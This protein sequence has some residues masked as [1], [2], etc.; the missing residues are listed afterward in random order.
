MGH[1][2]QRSDQECCSNKPI[3]LAIAILV[4]TLTLGAL[5]VMVLRGYSIRAWSDPVNWLE[6]A[7]NFWTEF[8]TSRLACGYPLFLRA[9]LLF[10]GPYLVF[11][12]NL[13]LLLIL[14]GAAGAMA[15]ALTPGAAERKVAAALFTIAIGVMFDPWL[16]QVM[17]NPYRDP[18]SHVLLFG[19]LGVALNELPRAQWRASR[20]FTAGLLL[21]L[22][23]SVREPALLA[24][25]PMAGLMIARGWRQGPRAVVRAAGWA[26]AGT[27]AGAAPLLAQGLLRA[28]D[29]GLLPPQT[30]AE[31]RWLPGMHWVAFSEVAPQVAKYLLHWPR[32]TLLWALPFALGVGAAARDR[33]GPVIAL[34]VI[35]TVIYA[36]FYCF[37]WTFVP[38]Y[39]W[40]AVI[41]GAAVGGWGLA[42]LLAPLSRRLARGEWFSMGAAILACVAAATWILG[43]RPPVRRFRIV[44]AR[45]LTQE[46]ATRV[47]SGTK[48]LARRHFCEIIRWFNQLDAYPASWHWAADAVDPTESLRE[49]ISRE[50]AADRPVWCAEVRYG[51][52]RDIE[53]AAVRR[54]FDFEPTGVEPLELAPFGLSSAQVEFW[55]IRPWSTTTSVV[56]VYV[57]EPGMR[58]EVDARGISDGA[59][60]ILRDQNSQWQ[61]DGILSRPAVRGANF[62]ALGTHTGLLQIT[63]SAPHPV[64]NMPGIRLYRPREPVVLDFDPT[65]EPCCAA[66]LGEGFL[67]PPYGQTCVR[68]FGKATIRIPSDLLGPEG[69]ELELRWR[70]TKLDRSRTVGL[71]LQ[72]GPHTTK[73]RA[74]CDR[75]F[76][77]SRARAPAAPPGEATIPLELEVLPETVGHGIEL[78]WVSV[79]AL[80]VVRSE[81]TPDLA[82]PE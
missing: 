48:V 71:R 65:A 73:L 28:S 1:V 77:I 41:F 75:S 60:L 79:R 51:G 24:G 7:R 44:D 23:Y 3:R 27:L 21:G 6:F 67:R 50:F 17:T 78:E 76:T 59:R 4:G 5:A 26:L 34:L 31:R 61:H 11:L 2:E 47:P 29:S 25:I 35:P 36:L 56:E 64:P 72:S 80:E 16:V 14:L 40:L 8:F 19:S 32:A 38:R 70:G 20:V 30:L 68:A 15:A 9:I 18:L 22:A 69:A 55:R 52:R 13:P 54:A 39:V 81:G 74:P 66:W 53:W 43:L 10:T 37:Y 42:R 33:N 49:R 82:L 58:L 62:V 46:I 45:A 57:P 12:S 63:L